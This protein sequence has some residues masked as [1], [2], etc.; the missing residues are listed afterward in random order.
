MGEQYH[1][2]KNTLRN[3]DHFHVLKPGVIVDDSSKEN[4]V[5]FTNDHIDIADRSKDYFLFI[6]FA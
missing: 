5:I 2:E 1:L 3:K 6:T 4:W